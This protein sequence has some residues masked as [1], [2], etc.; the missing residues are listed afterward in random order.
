MRE[1]YSSPLAFKGWSILFLVVGC[2]VP[3]A[4]GG[5]SNTEGSVDA[6]GS[7]DGTVSNG[8]GSSSEDGAVGEDGGGNGG[9]GGGG[10]E[11][12]ASG[13]GGGGN[14]DGSANEDGGDFF[15]PD[16][17][18][19]GD[20]CVPNLCADLGPNA[21]GVILNC[22]ES[23]VCGDAGGACPTNLI[24]DGETHQCTSKNPVCKAQGAQCGYVENSCGVEINCGSCP[25]PEV[26]DATTHQCVACSPPTQ[27]QC[28]TSCAATLSGCGVTITCPTPVSCGSQVCS[29]LSGECCT[30][31]KCS[32]PG[33]CDPGGGVS[34]GCGNVL[35][36]CTPCAPPPPPTACAGKCGTVKDSCGDSIS[37]GT[38]ACNQDGGHGQICN[39]SN[40]CVCANPCGK[41]DCGTK[42]DS[43]GNTVT[44][45]GGSCVGATSGGTCG[46]GGTCCTP[47]G[48]C[49]SIQCAG[50]YQDPCT[51][52]VYDCSADA[53]GPQ[54][55]GGSTCGTGGEC[56]TPATCNADQCGSPTDPC[57]GATLSCGDCS[58]NTD[59]RTHCNGTTCCQPTTACNADQCGSPVDPCT[60]NALS[61]GD[62]S[63]N[64][65]GRTHCNGTN[66]CQPA[67]CDTDQCGSPVDPCTGNA[68]SCGDCSTNTD[69]RT[70]CNGTTCC[71]PATACPA[72]YCGNYTD[73]CTG[74]VIPCSAG[75]GVNQ[76]CYDGRCCTPET[77]AT[78]GTASCK[79]ISPGCGL[80]PITCLT[81]PLG[82]ECI[83]N[84]TCCTPATCPAGFTGSMGDGCGGTLY[85]VSH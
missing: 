1:K 80:A 24:C 56:C 30:P 8:D 55:G 75:C 3:L 10:T 22:G 31:L 42:V 74:N 49:P 85:C 63:G 45:H 29:K 59:G 52:T 15:L 72:G 44:C 51:G 67:T 36:G 58:T 11:D 64:T 4:C 47:T 21:C 48:G 68:L 60:G 5:S 32:S 54:C 83:S 77:C 26:C 43:C 40:Q 57:T 33:V 39:A 12:G 62:C 53:G 14:E 73:P 46:V 50:T 81:C 9:D 84:G 70:H 19:A 41:N 69:G 17:A 79:P 6:G 7:N 66:C 71:Q 28:A 82:S 65:D 61:C 38:S 23:V 27:S 13:D 25:N 37:C 35:H 2:A 76:N 78:V 18:L 34:D 20:G 16:G